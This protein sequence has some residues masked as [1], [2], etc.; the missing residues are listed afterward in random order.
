MYKTVEL[1]SKPEEELRKV[2]DQYYSEMTSFQ[3]AFL[4][5]LI[6]EEQ[7]RKIV[8]IGVSAGGTTSTILF[9]L[10][11]L[12][13]KAEIYSVDLAEKWYRNENY[14][15]GFVVNKLFEN[16]KV[17]KNLHQ[18]LLGHSIPFFLDQI[19]NNI[20]FLILDTTHVLPGELLD[21]IVCLPYL[22]DGCVV[23][24]H[25]T[26]ENHLTC[27]NAEIATKLLFDTV[28]AEEKYLMWEKGVNIS[29]FP[30]IATF[31][32]NDKTR[33]EVRDLFSTM[34]TNWGYFL[35]NN[36]KLRYRESILKNYGEKYLQLFDKIEN[37]QRN[38]YLQKQITEHYGKDSGYL[39]IQWQNSKKVFL[40]GAGYYANLY[41][42]WGKL[43]GLNI[44]GFV[45]SDNQKRENQEYEGL[46]VYFLS[47]LPCKSEECSIV[48]AVD[49]RYQELILLNLIKTGYHNII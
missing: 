30:N 7:P 23:V 5:G 33:K 13:M 49:K 3:T 16:S 41:H 45:I 20:D 27:R 32:V 38:T 29:N 25:D 34:T 40:Y 17:E 43:N 12:N 26:I 18:F 42:Q 8:E 28:T 4:C 36:D 31:K 11:I 1:Y 2:M 48:I 9:C 6:K 15:T 24:M 44:D 39:K 10:K 46:P 22:R 21:F 35:D 14:K 19:G 37:L 47:E